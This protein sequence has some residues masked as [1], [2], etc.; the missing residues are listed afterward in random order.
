MVRF[1]LAAAIAMG[2]SSFVM[3]NEMNNDLSIANNQLHGTIVLRIDSRNNEATYTKSPAVLAS[4]TQAEK[5]A[6]NANYAKVPGER[7]RNELDRDGGTSSWYFYGSYPYYNS[8][9][10]PTCN[11][12]GTYYNPFYY[13]SYGYYGYYFYGPYYW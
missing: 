4:Q 3:A 8:Y 1:I 10:Y 12:Y 6:R 7:V 13:Y 2:A 11:W 9:Y 5:F